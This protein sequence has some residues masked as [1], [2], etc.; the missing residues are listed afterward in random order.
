[1][2]EKFKKIK[3]SEDIDNFQDDVQKNYKSVQLVL[4]IILFV[5]WGVAIVKIAVGMLINSSSMTADGYH[6]L[7]DGMSNVIGIIC[8]KFAS[9]PEDDEH[10]YG[11]NKIEAISGLIIG[12]ILFFVGCTVIESAYYKFLEPTVPN[13]TTASL[14]VLV[15][16]LC[17]NIIITYLESRKG[18]ELNSTILISDANHTKSDIFISFGV[19]ISLIGV[20]MGLSPMIDPFVTVIVSVFIFHACWEV[21]S[22]NISVLIDTSNLDSEK[23]KECVLQIEK[24]REVHNIRSR[25]TKNKIYVDMHIHVDHDMTVIESHKMQ[26]QIEELIQCNVDSNATVII[27]VEPYLDCEEKI[28]TFE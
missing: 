2:I 6:S 8:I 16:T 23:I 26:H 13:I 1:M 19:L 21:V 11:H 24:V 4:L 10:P 3:K 28:H 5:N 14:L 17:I 18:K 27:H 7:S 15:A 25:G 20:K 22:E 9:K 12:G